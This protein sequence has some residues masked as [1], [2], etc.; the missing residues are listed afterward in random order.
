MKGT[1]VRFLEE[2][3]HPGSLYQ[4]TYEVI[5]EDGDKSYVPQW[6]MELEVGGKEAEKS[7]KRH[8]YIQLLLLAI[9][10]AVAM[11]FNLHVIAM[12]GVSTLRI[13]LVAV[14][15]VGM[16]ATAAMYVYVKRALRLKSE[17]T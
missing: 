6:E 8:A 2:D 17:R 15:L 4:W 14:T 10:L 9:F 7:M 5:L 3:N 11:V 13:V 1:I 16:A 12:F